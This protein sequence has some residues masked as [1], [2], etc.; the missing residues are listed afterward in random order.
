ML[1][2]LTPDPGL[3]VPAKRRDRVDVVVAID[4][5]RARPQ[6]AGHLMGSAHITSPYRGGKPIGRVVALQD[7]SMLVLERDDSSHGAKDV[8]T[9]NL[10]VVLHI[11]KYRGIDKEP[12]A[13]SH[14]AAN[15]RP[16]AFLFANIEVGLY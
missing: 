11:D 2:K 16:G 10:H 12:F 9:R 14:L 6:R 15:R 5:H 7:R 3:L 13:R 4:P 1:A 8:F